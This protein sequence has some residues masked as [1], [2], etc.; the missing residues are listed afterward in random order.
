M[1][2]RT[3][4]DVWY[5]GYCNQRWTVPSVPHNPVCPRC[6]RG[7]WW[8]RFVKGTAYEVTDASD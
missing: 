3:D 4:Y 5:C 2:S 8:K 7:G 1:P 6:G